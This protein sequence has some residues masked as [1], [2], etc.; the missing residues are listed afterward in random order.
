MKQW[1]PAFAGMTAEL[2]LVLV[3]MLVNTYTYTDLSI[4]TGVC[5]AYKDMSTKEKNHYVSAGII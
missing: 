4:I 2:M 5:T 3:H 1:I